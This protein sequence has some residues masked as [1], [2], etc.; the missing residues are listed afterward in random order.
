MPDTRG[1]QLYIEAFYELSSCRV[2][3]MSLGAIPFTSIAEY[4]KIF[5]IDGEEFFEFLHYIRVMDNELL[6][7]DRKK[8]LNDSKKSGKSNGRNAGKTNKNNG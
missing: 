5:E 7:L 8:N 6:S 4:A 3:S 2:S 1:F